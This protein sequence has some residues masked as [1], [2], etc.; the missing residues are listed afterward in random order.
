VALAYASSATAQ[1]YNYCAFIGE[2]TGAHDWCWQ[3]HPPE[4]HNFDSNTA[5]YTG[6]GT[7]EYCAALKYGNGEHV[8]GSPHCTRPNI[9]PFTRVYFCNSGAGTSLKAAVGNRDDAAHTIYAQ[10][11][12]IAGCY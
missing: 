2:A 9:S 3:G 4:L 10:A 12:V 7:F 11:T 5:S 8:A 1:D 6:G